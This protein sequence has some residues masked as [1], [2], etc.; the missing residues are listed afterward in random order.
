M[1]CKWCGAQVPLPDT[2]PG[3]FFRVGLVSL[4]VAAG[5]LAVAGADF[6]KGW[7]VPALILFCTAMGGVLLAAAGTWTALIDCRSM[8]SDGSPEPGR[9]C[10]ACGKVTPLRPWSR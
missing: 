7:Q 9:R 6:A 2:A 10:G 1:D 8:A 5:A 4:L 3:T